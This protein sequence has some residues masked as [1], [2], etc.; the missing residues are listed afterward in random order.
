VERAELTPHVGLAISGI[1]GPDLVDAAVASDLRAALARYG[2]VVYREAHLGDDDLVALSRLLGEVVVPP[3]NDAGAHP[4]V[5]TITMDP[6]KS[7]LAALRKGNFLWHIDG[8]HDAVPQK[9]TLLT[10]HEVDPA[11]GDTEFAS[12]YAAYQAV[13]E[14]EKQRIADLRVIHR[15]SRP[16]RISFPEASPK[17]QAA[18]AKV[19]EQVHPLVWERRDGRRSLMIGSTADEIVGWSEADG[20][21]LLDHL[22]ELATRSEFTYRHHWTVGDLV[23]WDN[24]GLLH[25]ALPFEPTSRR[26]LHRTTL[27]GEERVSAA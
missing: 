21:S 17:Q 19:P 25:R 8:T 15:F 11:G 13:P 10:A 6:A 23:V 24:T 9:A 26:V 2:V 16:M 7:K 20:R 18:W 3:V 12:T 14:E 22:N 1:R 5:A 4:E 27:V